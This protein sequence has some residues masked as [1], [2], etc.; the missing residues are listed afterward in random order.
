MKTNKKIFI[1]I[2]VCISLYLSYVMLLFIFAFG[3]KSVPVI[4]VP[5]ELKRLEEQLKIETNSSVQFYQIE[6]HCIDDCNAKLELNMYI[7]NITITKSHESLDKYI[8]SVKKRVNKQLINKKCIDSIVISVSSFEIIK[9]YSFP[10]T[11]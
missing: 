8:N 11:K 9:R 2:G 5:K 10:I 6:K 7:N 4:E 1:F 3:H